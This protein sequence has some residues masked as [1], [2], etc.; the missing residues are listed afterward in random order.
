MIALGAAGSWKYRLLTITGAVASFFIGGIILLGVGLQ[1]ILLLGI[2]FVTS[3]LLSRYKQKRKLS[4]DGLHEKGSTR[5]WVQVLAN[6][7]AA[8]LFAIGNSLSPH[9]AW[10]IAFSTSLASANS[11]TWASELGVLSKRNPVS[12]K[13]FRTVPRGTSGAVSILGTFSAALGSMVIALA[14]MPL[15]EL[16]PKWAGIV[17]IFGMVGMLTDA[18][19]GACVQIVYQCKECG[20]KTE[21]K[22]HCESSTEKSSGFR[23][24]NNDAVNFSASLFSGLIGIIMFKFL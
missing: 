12:L 23:F 20:T 18:L 17:F 22:M 9:P 14:S 5:D 1:G 4:L 8:A 6:G 2:F 13:T 15:F 7:G 19:L 3:S 16:E 10:L 11:D 21:K 24:M